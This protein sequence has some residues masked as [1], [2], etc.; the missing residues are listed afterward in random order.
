LTPVAGAAPQYRFDP[1][2]DNS[3]PFHTFGAVGVSRNGNVA[4]F[5]G[6]DPAP[7]VGSRGVYVMRGGAPVP[8]WESNN[9]LVNG[10]LG[11][12]YSTSTTTARSH[13]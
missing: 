4:F 8:V 1:I 10:T 11:V 9:S 2:I 5:A 12:P 7:V 6:G 3:G 13:C